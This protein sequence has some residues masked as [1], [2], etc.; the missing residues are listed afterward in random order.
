MRK[1]FIS[2]GAG[3]IGTA[4]VERLIDKNKIV[5]YDNF[6]RDSLKFSDVR[7]HPNLKVIQGDI[8]D[9][10]EL[11]SSMK[12]SNIVIHMAA[13]VG[14][15]NV[16]EHPV[17][18]MK[19]NVLGTMNV[20]EAAYQNGVERV[21]NFSTSE[22]FGSYAYKLGE[23][24]ETSLRPI[25]EARWVYATSKLTGEHLAYSYYKEL[26]LPTVSLRPFNIYGPRQIM[27]GAVHVLVD[28]AIR[29]QPLEIH[30]DG[31]QIRSWCYIDDMVD[32]IIL[33]FKDE[34][35][36]EVFN[37]GNPKG[38]ITILSLAAN[39]KRLAKSKSEIVYLPK[40]HADVELR[41]P[42]IDKAVEKLGFAPKIGLEEGLRRTIQWYR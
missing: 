18:T 15:K 37:F 32:G 19:V 42:S 30:G 34:A 29:N 2:G 1:I 21:L 38:T 35:I 12:G 23:H 3:F 36:G 24:N 7:S 25:G 16:V 27:D 22:V 9:S 11:H 6:Y 20:L 31:D 14:V 39:I 17:N 5:V 4:L 10:K 8:L 41:I 33:C 13:T 40:H 26:G 28:R